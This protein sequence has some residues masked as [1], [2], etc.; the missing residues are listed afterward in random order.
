MKTATLFAASVFLAVSAGGAAAQFRPLT[1]DN[2]PNS[3]G[4]TNLA[5]QNGIVYDDD[6]V[7]GRGPNQPFLV[8]EQTGEFRSVERR[9]Q[10]IRPNSR[11]L[12]RADGTTS[13]VARRARDAERR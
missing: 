10:V 5:Y 6:L 2:A 4:D 13:R 1:Q 8:G 11:Q 7:P 3:F 9:E 12:I